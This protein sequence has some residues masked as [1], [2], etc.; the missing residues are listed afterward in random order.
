MLANKTLQRKCVGCRKIKDKSQLIRIAKG[1]GIDT[2][3]KA[4]GRGAYICKNTTCI[5]KAQKSKGL[6]R[7][8][9][10]TQPQDIYE[11][12]KTHLSSER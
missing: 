9:K 11:T 5:A 3:G 12:L 2:S 6:E 1:H 8:L 10:C 7:S 4:Q